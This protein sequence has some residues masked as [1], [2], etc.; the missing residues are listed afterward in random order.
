MS[1]RR[2]G[3]SKKSLTNEEVG[4]RDYL[5][6]CVRDVGCNKEEEAKARAREHRVGHPHAPRDHA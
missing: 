6:E 1:K 3:R 4:D 2:R 5:M